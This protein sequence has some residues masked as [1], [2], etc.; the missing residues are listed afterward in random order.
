MGFASDGHVTYSYSTGTVTFAEIFA[1]GFVGYASRGTISDCNSLTDVCCSGSRSGGFVGQNYAV[2]FS[3][4]YSAGHV[5]NA[6]SLFGGF[7]G[8][9]YNNTITTSCF[10]DTQ[11]S[12]QNNSNGGTDKSNTQMKTQGTFTEWDFTTGTGIWEIETGSALSY[13]YLRQNAQSPVPG[14]V[15]VDLTGSGTTLDPYQITNLE[16]LRYLSWHS[17]IWSATFIQTTDIDASATTG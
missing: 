16:D 4:C 6:E 11:T 8:Y 5:E 10:W 17:I 9:D 1:G 3:R 12:G 14:H 7:C 2:L 15:T 13:P